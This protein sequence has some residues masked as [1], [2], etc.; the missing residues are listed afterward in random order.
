M[1]VAFWHRNIPFI[2][3]RGREEKKVHMEL[4]CWDNIGVG[5]GGRVVGGEQDLNWAVV[6]IVGVS[7]G[8][9]A[10]QKY[11]I[12]WIGNFLCEHKR[13]EIVP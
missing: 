8:D 10:G 5:W 4:A 13:G 7:E 3:P 11:E 1:K 6:G 12:C 9:G 2:S